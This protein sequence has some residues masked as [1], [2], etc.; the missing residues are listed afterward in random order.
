MPEKQLHVVTGAFGYSGKYIARRLL[1]AGHRVRTLTNSVNRRNPF[2]GKVEAHLF[3]FDKPRQLIDSLRGA[4]VLYNTY[5][6][7]FNYGTFGHASAVENTLIL[8]Q[9]AREAGV[10]RVVHVSITNPSEDSELEY[11]R[12]KARLERA[13]RESGLSYAIL[14]PAVLFGKED[15]LINNIAWLLRKLPIATVFGDGEYRLQPIHVDDL[16]KLAVEQGG[17]RDNCI[18]NAIGPETF[19]YRELVRE[20]GAIIGKRRPVV[21]VPPAVGYIAAVIIGKIVGD[22]VVT[23]DEIKGLMNDLLY[24]DSPPAGTTRLTEWARAHAKGLG[25]R[26]VSELARRKDRTKAYGEL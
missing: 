12:G 10:E 14:R 24:V 4:A 15:I 11:F 25:S 23:R 21:G 17:K 3:N 7:R 20:I 8:F 2:G 9:A 18:I 19:T 1:D 5:W 6:V 13:L 22:V 26:Y 16:A